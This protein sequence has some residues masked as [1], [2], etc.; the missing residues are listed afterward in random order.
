M[1]SIP[2]HSEPDGT[3]PERPSTSKRYGILTV[4]GTPQF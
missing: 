2:N 3:E 4:G 1:D